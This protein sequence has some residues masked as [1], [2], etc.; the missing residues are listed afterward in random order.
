MCLAVSLSQVYLELSD[1]ERLG[2]YTVT[3]LQVP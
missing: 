3:L 1:Y 2:D